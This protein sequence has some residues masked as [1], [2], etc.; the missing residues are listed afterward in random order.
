MSLFNELKRRNV[1]RVAIAYLVIAW[2]IVQ[3]IG[4]LS[5]MFDVSASFQ[6]GVVLVLAVGFIPAM[7]FAWAFE[8]TPEGI[9]KKK[10]M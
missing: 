6:R 2:V 4:V 1:I 7:F 9:K 3:V 5:P 8:I 10:K